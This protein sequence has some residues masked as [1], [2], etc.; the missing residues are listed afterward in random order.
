ML[1]SFEFTSPLSDTYMPCSPLILQHL[2]KIG[3]WEW[4]LLSWVLL[5]LN[6]LVSHSTYWLYIIVLWDT[7]VRLLAPEVQKQDINPPYYHFTKYTEY[8]V[9]SGLCQT[10]ASWK[11]RIFPSFHCFPSSPQ[12]QLPIIVKTLTQSLSRD[13]LVLFCFVLSILFLTSWW[14]HILYY[15]GLTK[16]K[17]NRLFW[18]KCKSLAFWDCARSFKKSIWKS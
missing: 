10:L 8:S 7:T 9:I 18:G 14:W 6:T 1:G 5:W 4:W 2:W 11:K 3:V 16:L 15:S 12:W 17:I 13:N